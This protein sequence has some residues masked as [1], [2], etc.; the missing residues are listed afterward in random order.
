MRGSEDLVR[1]FPVVALL[2]LVDLGVLLR[3]SWYSRNHRFFLS[4]TFLLLP[5][6]LYW[7][8]GLLSER[9]LDWLRLK[10]NLLLW[11]HRLRCFQLKLFG[12]VYEMN[13]DLFFLCR[14]AIYCIKVLVARHSIHCL[15]SISFNGMCSIPA[16]II[17]GCQSR[18]VFLGWLVCL[19]CS[20]CCWHFF[21]R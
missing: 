12:L 3:Q 2:D 6:I 13:L 20:F 4:F 14:V 5:D 17:W 10:Y 15:V 21:C 8:E 1:C 18:A 19:V 9:W 16:L 11:C 7:P